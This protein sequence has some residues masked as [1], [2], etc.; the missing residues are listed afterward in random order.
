I[1]FMASFAELAGQKLGD[2]DAPDSFNI[3]PALLGKSHQG[4]DH[5]VEHA[6]VLSII[7]RDW[8]YIEPGKGPKISQNTNIE[9]GIDQNPQLYNLKTDLAE[10]QNLAEAHPAKLEELSTLLGRIKKEGR[11]RR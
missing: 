3:L 1:D 11:S 4:R 5:L 6:R 9:L 7:Q 8:K 2:D 10:T